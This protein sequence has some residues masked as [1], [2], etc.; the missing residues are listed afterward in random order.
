MGYAIETNDGRSLSVN[1]G[2]AEFTQSFKMW[3]YASEQFVLR[4]FGSAIANGS[5]VGTLTTVPKIGSKH[6]YFNTLRCWSYDLRRE[7]SGNDTWFVTFKF[8]NVPH[9]PSLPQTPSGLSSGPEAIGFE[10]LTARTTVVP[11]LAWRG[12]N[13]AMPEDNGLWGEARGDIGGDPLDAGGQPQTVFKW[14]FEITRSEVSEQA[15]SKSLSSFGFQTGYRN[16]SEVFGFPAG[17]VIYKGAN[18]TRIGTNRYRVSH[19]YT[20]DSFYH[21]IQTMGY[22]ADGQFDV[23]EDGY[24]DVVYWTQPFPSGSIPS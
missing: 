18:I 17:T 2:K 20:Y 12:G 9:N 7:P 19:A 6:S 24:A 22:N 16:S 1:D 8:R 4:D 11:V 5:G 14:Q 13:M 10:E 23:N 21:A 3:G 15:F